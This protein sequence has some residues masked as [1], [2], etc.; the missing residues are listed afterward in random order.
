MGRRDI[1]NFLLEHGARLDLFAAAMLGKLNIV[2][3]VLAVYPDAINISG[4]HN[5]PLI[6]HAKSGSGEA[7]AVL[8]FLLS[9]SG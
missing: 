1:A 9:Q 7:K 3:A 2:K 4:P 8:D 6:E 5:I